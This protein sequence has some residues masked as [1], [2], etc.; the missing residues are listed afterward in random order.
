M[1]EFAKP[2]AL[3]W[4]GKGERNARQLPFKGVW[5]T[6]PAGD[7]GI[8]RQFEPVTFQNLRVADF[9]SGA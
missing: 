2:A 8:S 4:G 5:R 3:E 7:M 1:G 9:G 6:G